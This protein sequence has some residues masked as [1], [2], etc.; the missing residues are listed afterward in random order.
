MGIFEFHWVTS[1]IFHYSILSTSHLIKWIKRYMSN[2]SE[3][4]LVYC[5]VNGLKTAVLSQRIT[6]TLS[7]FIVGKVQKKTTEKF[8]LMF[9]KCFVCY[10]EFQSSKAWLISKFHRKS[11][12][13]QSHHRTFPE[14]NLMAVV[15][16]DF[17][18][19]STS[20]IYW[21]SVMVSSKHRRQYQFRT[22][23]YT[24]F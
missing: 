8:F 1:E 10:I 9:L 2:A 21:A 3:Q 6:N 16:I 23:Y 11:Y 20:R 18:T 17:H 7:W 5:K 4:D 13:W 22:N 15:D 24:T 12:T 19:L 14:W